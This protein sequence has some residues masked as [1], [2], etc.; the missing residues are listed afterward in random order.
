MDQDSR[1]TLWSRI[2]QQLEFGD[3]EFIEGLKTNSGNTQNSERILI[4]RIRE[5]LTQ[6]GLT[7]QEAGSQQSKDFRNVGGIGLDIEVKK[8]DSFSVYFN[9]TLPSPDIYYIV[10]FTGKRYQTKPDLPPKIIYCNGERFIRESPWIEEY[11]QEIEKLKDK[12]ARGE[13]KKKLPGIMEV[14]PRP[15]YKANI[16][17]LIRATP[18]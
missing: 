1:N 5:R 18:S 13:A 12:Y 15:T 10:V 16:E 14:Y 9:D 2:Q 17:H 11:R 7:F 6:M 4:T 3:L 8:T